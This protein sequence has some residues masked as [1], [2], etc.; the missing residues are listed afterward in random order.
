VSCATQDGEPFRDCPF[1]T[2]NKEDGSMTL[3]VFI[4]NGEARLFY[5]EDGEITGTNSLGDLGYKRGP[6]KTFAHITPTE[7][8]EFPNEV[9]DGQ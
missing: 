2:T 5:I 9:L 1:E 4:G 3:R 6:A 8:F 7:R